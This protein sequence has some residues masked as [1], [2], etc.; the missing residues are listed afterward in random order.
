MAAFRAKKIKDG[1]ILKI[2]DL[3]NENKLKGDIDVLGLVMTGSRLYGTQYE[4]GENP[5]DPNYVSD[6][7]Y[8]GVFISDI[9]NYLRFKENTNDTAQI[10]D[11]EDEEYYSIL[12]FIRMAADNNPNIMDILF[13]PDD[14]VV[15]QTPAFKIIRDNKEKFITEGVKDKFAGYAESQLNRI[16][17]H[18]RFLTQYPYIHDIEESLKSAHKNKDIDFNWISHRFSGGLA[19][20]VTGLSDSDDKP[21][22]SNID[23]EEFREKYG[24]DYDITPY[25]RPQ[26]KD[27]MSFKSKN[28][29]DMNEG[30]AID[31]IKK[32]HTFGSYDKVSNN[33][34]EI[35]RG[36]RGIFSVDGGLK[37]NSTGSGDILA[38]AKINSEAYN[39]AKK[40]NSNLWS[41][42]V[43]R[44][45]KRA[46][47]EKVYG[48]DTKHAMHLFRL[49]LGAKKIILT[50][51]YN[52]R[53]EG[54]DLKIVKKIREGR[55]DYHEVIDRSRKLK[56]EIG[57]IIKSGMHGIK[58][59]KVDKDFV[60]DLIKEV[61]ELHNK[62]KKELTQK[63]K[64]IHKIKRGR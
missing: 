17:N 60:D 61:Y 50:G 2:Q 33:L 1:N 32:L 49:L 6:V 9:F 41:W 59:K 37:N 53:L 27:F 4:L 48:Y 30:D 8:R 63:K 25:L 58:N 3:S 42:H 29:I 55:M 52:P 18:R 13:A 45:E 38:Y 22:H 43:G 7:D 19:K 51:T 12:K 14:A 54:E 31:M 20:R 21:M 26:V 35:K 11:E 39:A 40:A 16:L 57:E 36:G 28:M 15:Y 23:L 5:L 56:I 10:I 64:N 44:N 62:F 46:I 34:I 24:V 47:L